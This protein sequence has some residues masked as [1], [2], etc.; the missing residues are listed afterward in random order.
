MKMNI[1]TIKLAF[2]PLLLFLFISSITAQTGQISGRVS[3]ADGALPFIQISLTGTSY[4]ALSNENGEFKFDKLPQGEYKLLVQALG[5]EYW[6]KN[7]KLKTDSDT[8]NLDIVLSEP[9]IV[10]SGTARAV[11][12]MQSAVA[13][14]VFSAEYFNRN[15]TPTIFEALQNVNGVRPQLNCNVCNTGDIHINGLEGPY[16]MVLID[17]MPIVSGLA[18][19]YGLTGIPRALIE[20]VEVVKGPASTLY[21]SEA[22]GGLI[23][24]ITKNVNCAPRLSLDLMATSWGEINADIGLKFAV[25]KKAQ[26]LL[27]IN[28]FNYQLPI[29]YNNDG[30]T[31]VALQHRLSIFNK[32][33][34]RRR[35]G[36]QFS[37]AAR[38]V[39]E[40]RWGGDMNW[41]PEHRG[42]DSLY[43]ESVHTQRW[44]TFGNYQL[45]TKEFILFQWSA[46]GHY[47]DSYYGTTAYIA[48]QHI[49]FG[50]LT[51]QKNLEKHN[52]LVGT[53]LRY[54]LYDDN[55]PA[56]VL[57]SSTLLPGV[58]VQEQWNPNKVHT[59]LAG[60]RYDYNQRHGNIFSPR[61]NYRYTSKNQLN[62]FRLG[63]G[64]GYRVANVF[65]EDHAALTGARQVV[66]L[67]AL[68]PETSWNANLNFVKKIYTQSNIFISLDFGAF[69]TYFSNRIQPDY[70]T[71]PNQIIYRNLDGNAV[72]KGVNANIDISFPFGLN[73]FAGTTIMDVIL[74]ENSEKIRPVL[75]ER[76]SAVWSASYTFQKP[77]ISIDYTANLYSPMRLP[78]LSELDP[79]PEYSPWWSI[80]NIQVTKRWKKDTELYF[81]V[82]NFLNYTPPSNSIAR[83]RDPFDRQVQFD[84]N[85]QAVATPQ[86][87]YALTFDPSYVFAPNQG[88]RFFVGVRHH[89]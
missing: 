40:N 15:P 12:K 48:N 74:H 31:D 32:W 11:T 36:R 57:P 29:D 22:V 7:V 49:A 73:V 82:K 17:G 79:R 6:Q 63:L 59:F 34:I 46:N 13:V 23:N 83:P 86:N 3:D 55:S 84:A 65:T 54:T 70:D 26:S 33:D 45:P 81:G 44:E 87:P 78:L 61:L 47:Q 21:G 76:I 2:L 5:Y 52:L 56:T 9:L 27:G 16:T 4:L 72:S 38:Y 37:F 50:Q 75:T 53:A 69:Y 25:K 77:Q 39:G 42:T 14:D 89:W 51:W 43:A 80:Q 28:Y 24:V 10:V 66:F 58:F 88:I 67:E 19:V 18:T 85:G 1:L 64:N 62:T 30:F 68:K 41:K 71:N 20:R 8:L 60:I 35:E